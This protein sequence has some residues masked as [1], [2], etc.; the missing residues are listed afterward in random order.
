M[1]F[2]QLPA[3]K[4]LFI[5]NLKNQKHNVL[6]I[7]DGLND[8][9]AIKVADVGISVTENTANFP[10]ASDVILDAKMFD[11]LP[12]FINYGKQTLQIIKA[13]FIISLIYNL[14]GL[15]FAVQGNLSP[16]FAAIIM[17]ISSI[18]VI[19]ITSSLTYL[20]A[21]KFNII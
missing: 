13:N 12:L 5:N 2:N 19:L 7:G 20:V 4:M 17:P 8:S 16:L 18:S 11:K 10:P 3:D 6:M 9:G 14:V 15:Y 1:F 21:K